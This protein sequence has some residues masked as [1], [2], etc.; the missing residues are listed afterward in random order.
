MP[1]PYVLSNSVA[2]EVSA[3]SPGSWNQTN[4]QIEL[5]RLKQQQQKYILLR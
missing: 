5:L 3:K 1:V 2:G 4:V